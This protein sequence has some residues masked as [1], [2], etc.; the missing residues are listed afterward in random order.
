MDCTRRKL[1]SVLHP[2]AH[3]FVQ[4]VN[5]PITPDAAGGSLLPGSLR[6][7]LVFPVSD[8]QLNRLRGQRG[9]R[10][11]DRSLRGNGGIVYEFRGLRRDR[12]STSTRRFLAPPEEY[13]GTNDR[14]RRRQTHAQ[15]DPN[16]DPEVPGTSR[17]VRPGGGASILD[18]RCRRPRRCPRRCQRR[19]GR[20][21]RLCGSRWCP[22]GGHLR[23]D[24]RRRLAKGEYQALGVAAVERTPPLLPVVTAVTRTIFNAVARPDAYH[25]IV[26]H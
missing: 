3:S 10:V 21:G 24:R 8:G 22:D 4:G 5:S 26:W 6:R 1:N 19:V 14:C 2:N 18:V 16:S 17:A 23:Q 9:R 15:P 11:R 13:R 20:G 7:Q 12:R 25:N